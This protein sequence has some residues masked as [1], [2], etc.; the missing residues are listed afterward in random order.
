MIISCVLLIFTV[1]D[2]LSPQLQQSET[3]KT[4]LNWFLSI[5][6]KLVNQKVPGARTQ[7]SKSSKI[8]S[9]N[10]VNTPYDLTDF[11]V[12]GMVRNIKN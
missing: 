5:F 2:R 4:H 3:V 8:F 6:S 1:F 7:S 11:E 12:D 9:K 10:T